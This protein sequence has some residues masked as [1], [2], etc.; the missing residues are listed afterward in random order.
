MATIHNN[1]DRLNAILEIRSASD[2]IV[3]LFNL[4]KSV[5]PVTEENYLSFQDN[6]IGLL[7]RID[8]IVADDLKYPVMWGIDPNNRPFIAFKYEYRQKD[9]EKSLKLRT[10][11]LFQQYPRWGTLAN[12]GLNKLYLGKPL[13]VKGKELLQSLL[14]GET[15]EDD[16]NELSEEKPHKVY[17][18]KLSSHNSTTMKCKDKKLTEEEKQAKKKSMDHERKLVRT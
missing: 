8:N 11:T 2:A 17:E 10:Q 18:Y 7:G 6:F 13:N 12:S 14:R 15:I 3:H 16:P 1:V 9:S 5:I 4:V